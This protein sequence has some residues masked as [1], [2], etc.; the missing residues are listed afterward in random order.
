MRE[1]GQQHNHSIKELLK[2]IRAPRQFAELARLEPP[3]HERTN[4]PE[5]PSGVFVA[6]RHEITHPSMIHHAELGLEH[7][8]HQP[9]C[10]R[11]LRGVERNQRG[12]TGP[13]IPQE[14]FQSAQHHAGKHR[15]LLPGPGGRGGGGQTVQIEQN[16]FHGPN[17]AVGPQRGQCLVMRG[18]V[19]AGVGGGLGSKPTRPTPKVSIRYRLVAFNDEE[20]HAT[21][22]S[23]R[24]QPFRSIALCS[25]C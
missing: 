19:L 1:N 11:P 22:T 5:D 16:G 14:A 3:L 15:Q 17:V 25:A 7:G 13:V 24:V 2:L 6:T 21:A 9:Q 12:E 8:I 20:G 10:V 23:K 4:P 18:A